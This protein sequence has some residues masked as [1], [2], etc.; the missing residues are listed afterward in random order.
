MTRAAVAMTIALA[1]LSC[2][3]HRTPT[4]TLDAALSNREA[5][6]TEEVVAALAALTTEPDP[7][8]TDSLLRIATDAEEEVRFDAIA[9]LERCGKGEPRVA[10]A[11]AALAAHDPSDLV[12]EEAARA[13]AT[14]RS[15]SK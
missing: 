12:R 13:A 14:G 15:A 6:S 1:A 5:V 11:L 10:A 7:H 9:A 4:A 3:G 8:A 2:G